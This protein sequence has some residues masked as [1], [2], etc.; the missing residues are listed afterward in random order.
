M[1]DELKMES[2]IDTFKFIKELELPCLSNMSIIKD[3]ETKNNL[4]KIQINS[5]IESLKFEY[6][7]IRSSLQ[8]FD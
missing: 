6:N 7:F 8:Q 2:Q 5:L 1:S 3:Y 4:N